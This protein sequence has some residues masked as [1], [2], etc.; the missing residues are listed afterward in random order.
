MS[1][2]VG[3]DVG[4]TFTDFL[5]LDHGSA[6]FRTAKVPT[7][8]DDRA[9]GFLAGIEALAVAPEAIDWLVHGTTAG[10]N[11]VLERKSAPVGLIT[12][13][14]FRDTLE[15]G[16]RTRPQPYGLAGNVAPRSQCLNIVNKN[17]L[18][19]A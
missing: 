6:T 12:T 7:T 16:R 4:G 3:V 2:S 13:Q 17:R 5:L 8:V 14:G 11:A 1:V 10:T 15:L 9:R 19:F 18:I